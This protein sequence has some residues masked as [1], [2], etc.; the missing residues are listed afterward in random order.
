[1]PADEGHSEGPARRE[2]AS[3]VYFIQHGDHGPIK[4]GWAHDPEQRRRELQTGNPEQLHVRQLVP[5]GRDLEG[6]IHNRFADWHL[7][8]EWFGGG[9]WSAVILTYAAG[10]ADDRAEVAAGTGERVEYLAN[11]RIAVTERERLDLRYDIERLYLAG[12]NPDEIADDLEWVWGLTGAEIKQEIKA[13]RRTT[14]W[15]VGKR[16][17]PIRYGTIRGTAV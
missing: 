11:G 2:R 7:Q 9:E 17:R 4:V 12:F 3:F 6:Q 8:G 16:N 13:M 15:D 1:M 10:L 5:G 14:V